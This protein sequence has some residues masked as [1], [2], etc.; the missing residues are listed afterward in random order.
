MLSAEAEDY[1]FR[2]AF[3][4]LFQKGGGTALQVSTLAPSRVGR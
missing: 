4:Q 2:L 1:V 3:Q